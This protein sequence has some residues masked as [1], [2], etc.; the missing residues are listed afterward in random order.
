M[1]TLLHITLGIVAVFILTGCTS[2]QD[3]IFDW[4]NKRHP[5]PELPPSE[6]PTPPTPPTTEPAESNSVADSVP[7]DALR[8]NRGGENFAKAERDP[9]VSLTK[10]TIS[11]SGTPTLR[12]EGIGL[13]V[14]PIKDDNINCIWAIFFDA[15]GDGIFERGG[16]FDWGRNNAAPRPLHHLLDYKGWDGYPAKGTRWAAVITDTKG[17]L[18]SNVATGVWP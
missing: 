5:I 7:F 4:L 17:K 12:Y 10:V 1:K 18:R 16:K 8:W 15:D 3:K 9:K 2:L 14:W 11:G 6:Q 13:K